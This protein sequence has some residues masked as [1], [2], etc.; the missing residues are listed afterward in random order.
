MTTIVQEDTTPRTRCGYTPSESIR[1]FDKAMLESGVIGTGKAL[2]F[3]ADILTSGGIDSFVRSIWDYAI[4]HVG[5]A[6]P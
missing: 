4:S 2:H 6:S 3:G 5:I 1:A